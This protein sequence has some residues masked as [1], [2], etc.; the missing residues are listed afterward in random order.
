MQLTARTSRLCLGAL[1]ALG[2]SPAAPTDGS[3]GR[4]ESDDSREEI[5]GGTTTSAFPATG[6]S[7]L[8]GSMHCTGTLIAP[9]KV[10]TAAHCLQQVSASALKFVIGPSVS[11]AQTTLSVA[12]IK[13]HPQYDD[14]Q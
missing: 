6:A 1:L 12:S 4:E 8:Y 10:V 14:Q 11:S 3:R 13:P 5:V 2:C 7:T 9:R